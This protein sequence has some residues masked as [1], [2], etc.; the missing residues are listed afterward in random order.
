MLAGDRVRFI[1]EKV[2]VVAAEDRNVAE[3]ATQLIEVEY[4]ELPPVFDPLVAIT[5]GAPQLHEGLK[6]YQGL[7]NLA[8]S[9]NNVYSHDEWGLGDVEQGFRESD[10]IFE[11]TFTTQHVHQSYLEPHSSVLSIDKET[12]DS[13]LDKQQGSLPDKAESCRCDWRPSRKNRH[14]PL[15]DRR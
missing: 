15:C 5:E 1:G 3:E 8:S 13:C 4:E 14:S 12:G 11:D 7:P 9:I 10:H 6:N 2:A